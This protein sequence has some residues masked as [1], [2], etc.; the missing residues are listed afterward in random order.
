MISLDKEQK[1]FEDFFP[2]MKVGERVTNVE[3]GEFVSLVTEK[4]Y[5]II[6]IIDEEF[7]IITEYDINYVVSAEY[8]EYMKTIKP[9]PTKSILNAAPTDIR[10][11]AKG[12]F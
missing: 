11:N 7:M 12:V 5:E 2:I 3:V 9:K 1:A 10:G 6:P 4:K 8:A